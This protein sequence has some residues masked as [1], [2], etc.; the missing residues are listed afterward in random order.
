MKSKHIYYSIITAFII[1]GL[2]HIFAVGR[3][4]YPEFR[5]KAGQVSDIDVIAP[6]SFPVLKSDSQLSQEKEDTLA[7]INKP[8][9][10]SEDQLFEAKSKLDE[11]FIAALD[12]KSAGNLATLKAAVVAAGFDLQDTALLPLLNQSGA[13][14]L[15]ESLGNKLQSLYRQGIFENIEGDSIQ[16]VRENGLQEVEKNQFLSLEQAREQ[17]EQ[18]F[19]DSE[20]APLVKELSPLLIKRNLVL[21]ETKLTEIST[22]VSRSIPNTLGIVQQ[23]EIIVRKNARISETD[24]NKINSLQAAYKNRDI[25]KS[26]IQTLLLALGLLL[27]YLVIILSANSYFF[28]GLHKNPNQVNDTLP[29]N[30]GF[31]IVVL[32]A[33]LNNYILGYNNI[34]IPFALTV[35][36]ATIL[37]GAEFSIFYGICS[38][39]VVS[40]FI[41]WET[42]TPIIMILYTMI[43]ILLI[44]RY[45]AYH[46]YLNIWFYLILSSAVV[47]L[48]LGV[49]K[50]DPLLTI[51]SN[52]G[53]CVISAT[54]SVI[55]LLL[56]VPHYEKKWQRA[57]KQ[58]LLELLDFDH[59]L[60][61]RLATEAV[62]TYHHSLIVGNLSERAAEAIGAN[63]LLARVGSYYHDIGK[64]V[65]TDIFTENN[66]DSTQIHEGIQPDESAKLIK[67]HVLEGIELARH[68]K[69]PKPVIDII[70]QHHGTSHIRYFLEQAKKN[71]ESLDLQPFTYPGPKP[72]SKEAVLVMLADIIESTTKAKTINSEADI[73]SIIDQT[74]ERLI[75][76]KQFDEAPITM[77]ELAIAKATMLPVLESIYRKRLDYPDDRPTN[78]SKA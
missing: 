19:I 8:F 43:T 55:G 52:I 61:K 23:N 24:I 32:L 66:E 31:V 37:I 30:S 74:I 22:D 36:S 50:N 67:G 13:E 54:I 59:P 46:E 56:I 14:V 76:D 26:S 6:F 12:P 27:F 4:N 33:L 25:A 16:V 65:N 2:Y 17:L 63:P 60:L 75:R 57:T 48:S 10:I 15:Y 49:Y 73:V 5:L 18:A 20:F 11:L 28:Y 21:D 41:N 70:M 38:L 3:F 53:Y 77:K 78:D 47:N 62:G 44:V 69:I 64:I 34:L 29:L 42:Y 1:V 45:N 9:R 68:Y 39:L 35:I 51:L 40:P 72:Q 71:H 7:G 58:T